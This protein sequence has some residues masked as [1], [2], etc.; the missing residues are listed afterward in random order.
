MSFRNLFKFMVLII[1]ILLA[2][3]IAIWIDNYLLTFRNSQRPFIFTWIGMVVVVAI[4]YPLFAHIDRWA[5]AF[6]EK[7][8]RSGN[9]FAG[10]KWGSLLI[11]LILLLVLYFFYGQ[12]W[13]GHNVLLSF[14]KWL[15][16]KFAALFSTLT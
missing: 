10:R 2:N 8:I 5:T 15:A 7:I 11:F 12:E 16:G 13:Y 9:K 3:L 6:S 14:F 1:S 4:Y